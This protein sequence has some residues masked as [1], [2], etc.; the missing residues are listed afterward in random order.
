MTLSEKERATVIRRF[1]KRELSNLR[2]KETRNL[3]VVEELFFLLRQGTSLLLAI[4]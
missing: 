3:L 1:L 2:E 4:A